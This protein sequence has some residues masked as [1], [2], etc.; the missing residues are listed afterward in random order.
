MNGQRSEKEMMIVSQSFYKYRLS[1]YEGSF[2]GR[3]EK[4]Q[5]GIVIYILSEK[6][7]FGLFINYLK[8]PLLVTLYTVLSA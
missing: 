3:K 1:A 2:L 4:I 8:F 6:E 7:R 5:K